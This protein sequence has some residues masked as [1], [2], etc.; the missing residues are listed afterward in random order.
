VEKRA[1][2]LVGLAA[3]VHRDDLYHRRELF[4]KRTPIDAALALSVADV[5]REGDGRDSLSFQV[6]QPAAQVRQPFHLQDVALRAL[7]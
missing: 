1:S 7:V 6:S 3:A 4:G 5:V 2:V